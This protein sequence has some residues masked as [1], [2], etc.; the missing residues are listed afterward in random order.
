M[1]MTCNQNERLRLL[2][3]VNKFGFAISDITLYLDTHPND[4]EALHY[5]HHMN[6]LYQKA[7]MEYEKKYG[8]LRQFHNFDE[9]AW[10]WAIQPWPWERGFY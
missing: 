6:Q 8:P 3:A 4:P 1:S 7:S 5:Y 9:N 10:K 2:D